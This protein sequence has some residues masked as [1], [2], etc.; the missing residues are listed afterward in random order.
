MGALL[1]LALAACRLPDPQAD[2]AATS[3][4]MPSER[5]R[6]PGITSTTKLPT[7]VM[8]QEFAVGMR[9][10]CLVVCKSC[11]AFRARPG[12]APDGWC[13]RYRTETWG[14]V[15]FKCKSYHRVQ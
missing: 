5:P 7:E 10:G 13:R 4:P 12:E 1:E 2:S 11:A 15:P 9:L 8:T 14:G 3:A 6:E